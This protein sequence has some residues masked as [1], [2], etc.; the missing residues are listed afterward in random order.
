VSGT[1]CQKKTDSN[2]AKTKYFFISSSSFLNVEL[3]TL[4]YCAP[5]Q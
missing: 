5:G 3:F 2:A 4:I 1:G